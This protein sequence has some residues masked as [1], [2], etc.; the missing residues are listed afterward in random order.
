MSRKYVHC[1]IRHLL[2][3]WKNGYISIMRLSMRS[4][5]WMEALNRMR[6]A[7]SQISFF[8][9][10][11]T[12]LSRRK[13]SS[14]VITTLH[15]KFIMC[16]AKR[17]HNATSCKLS[18][19]SIHIWYK[20]RNGEKDRM[21]WKGG[22]VTD[23]GVSSGDILR[24]SCASLSPKVWVLGQR[25]SEHTRFTRYNS[26]VSSISAAPFCLS[27]LRTRFW[28]WWHTGCLIIRYR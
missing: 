26:A 17:F 7:Y 13:N 8:N 19:L 6:M 14:V 16:S 25:K 11:G 12:T 24:S 1:A 2:N 21:D 15:A 23:W 3:N 4:E 28:D 5:C 27:V 10:R 18:N 22:W 9:P 20:R